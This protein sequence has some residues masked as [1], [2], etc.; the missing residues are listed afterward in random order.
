MPLLFHGRENQVFDV[1]KQQDITLTS[2][3]HEILR[4]VQLDAVF[5][6]NHD[7]R[8]F[9]RVFSDSPEPMEKYIELPLNDHITSFQ[10]IMGETLELNIDMLLQRGYSREF[11]EA[12]NNYMLIFNSYIFVRTSNNETYYVYLS[13]LESQVENQEQEDQIIEIS[14]LRIDFYFDFDNICRIDNRQNNRMNVLV[15]DAER[16]LVHLA[17]N[18]QA[19]LGQPSNDNDNSP[20]LIEYVNYPLPIKRLEDNYFIDVNGNV[21]FIVISAKYLSLSKRFTPNLLIGEVNSY[22][23]MR[24][25]DFRDVKKIHL[26]RIMLHI[27]YNDGRFSSQNRFKKDEAKFSEILVDDFI[28]SMRGILMLDMNHNLVEDFQEKKII[29]G[30]FKFNRPFPFS[31]TKRACQY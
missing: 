15:L 18:I 20:V 8:L 14:S 5:V 22:F 23:I 11:I 1:S 29:P 2:L 16:R 19:S 7:G 31:A 24:I 28:H 10:V 21:N 6:L 25:N 9:Y 4:P 30:P 27:L 3:D 12:D 26:G 13:M 17:I